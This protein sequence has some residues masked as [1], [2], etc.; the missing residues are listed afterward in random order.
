[1]SEKLF[2]EMAQSIIDGEDDAAVDLA[3]QAIAQGI[4]LLDKNYWTR[5]LIF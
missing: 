4:D 5:I 1:M 2:E 3:N